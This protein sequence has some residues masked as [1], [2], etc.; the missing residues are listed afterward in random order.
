MPWNLPEQKPSGNA[1]SALLQ[2]LNCFEGGR[3]HPLRF[4]V[5]L[6]VLLLAVLVMH[7]VSVAQPSPLRTFLEAQAG[8]QK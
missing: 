3:F 1:G 5:L 4:S 7:E 2:K 8:G 6:A